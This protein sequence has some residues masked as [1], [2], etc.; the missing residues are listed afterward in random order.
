M[1]SDL[2][3]L[4][5]PIV[6]APIYN[7]DPVTCSLGPAAVGNGKQINLQIGPFEHRVD[8]EFPTDVHK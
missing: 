5:C 8:K 6:K 4:D 1:Q 7:G 3:D 2:V